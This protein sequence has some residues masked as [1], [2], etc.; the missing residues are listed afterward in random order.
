MGAFSVVTLVTCCRTLNKPGS[1]MIQTSGKTQI[2]TNLP[3]KYS[4]ILPTPHEKTNADHVVRD[5]KGKSKMLDQKDVI[6]RRF[7]LILKTSTLFSQSEMYACVLLHLFRTHH[8][9]VV[10]PGN[11]ALMSHD[12]NQGASAQH[13]T[14][15]QIDVC[16]T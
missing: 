10:I 13:P 15:V 14:H 8:I 3:R 2:S 7:S 6:W 11:E 9:D 16:I 1:K 5:P 12:P 4:K